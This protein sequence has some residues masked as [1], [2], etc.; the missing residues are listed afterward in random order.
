[1]EEML[2]PAISISAEIPAAALAVIA[3][4]LSLQVDV[5]DGMLFLSKSVK[6]SK[7]VKPLQMIWLTAGS[8][9]NLILLVDLRYCLKQ[10]E[11]TGGIVV[12]CCNIYVNTIRR[13]KF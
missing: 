10:A 3:G 1:M 8:E 5:R 13:E 2:A 9:F 11:T 7:F 4:I 6:L 12:L